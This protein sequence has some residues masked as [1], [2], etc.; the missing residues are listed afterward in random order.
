VI[1]KCLR[2][3]GAAT[4]CV[5]VRILCLPRLVDSLGA[6]DVTTFQQH[7]VAPLGHIDGVDETCSLDTEAGSRSSLGRMLGGG[8]LDVLT[9]V[10]LKARL[11]AEDIQ[12]QLG[13]GM[14]HADQR[15]ELSLPRVERDAG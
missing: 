10:E 6:P 13:L 14:R 1:G 2:Q 3:F 5:T 8:R 11:G 9:G 4:L 15:L 12:V 7:L